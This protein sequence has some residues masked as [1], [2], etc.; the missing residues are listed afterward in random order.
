MILDPY[1]WV[2]WVLVQAA[3]FVPNFYLVKERLIHQGAATLGALMLAA[4]SY[5]AIETTL[6][7]PKP[8]ELQMF[9]AKE[10]RV[11]AYRI[12]R[13]YALY[14][15]LDVDGGGTPRA[16]SMRWS[17]E[18]SKLASTLIREMARAKHGDGEVYF[19]PSQVNSDSKVKVKYPE[20]KLIK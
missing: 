2:V 8:F 15:W 6:S 18:V 16:Y 17:P 7:Y 20:R 4:A 10:Y 14:L 13:D 12:D 11:L 3:Y 1:L 5:M 19:E 9:K